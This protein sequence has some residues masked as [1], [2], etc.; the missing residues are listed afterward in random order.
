MDC[1]FL[2]KTGN[3]TENIGYF[4]DSEREKA[5]KG[6]ELSG[7]AL[8][9]LDQHTA[10]ALDSK[11]SPGSQGKRERISNIKTLHF[12][13]T[14][15]VQVKGK[16]KEI[17][18]KTTRTNA[19]IHSTCPECRREIAFTTCQFC[20]K[21]E[22]KIDFFLTQIKENIHILKQVTHHLV[23]DGFYA[24]K[25]FISGSNDLGLDVITKLRVDANLQYLA[26]ISHQ[27]RRRGAPKK[28]DG[29]F[30]VKDLSRFEKTN[31]QG[32]VLYS[33]EMY[34]P[35]FQRNLKIVVI[36]HTI[37]CSTD[38]NL[39]AQEIF[40]IYS[41]R[42]QIEYLFR[43]GKSHMGLGDAQVR[44]SCSLNFQNNACLT[45]L[46]LL[47]LEHRKHQMKQEVI[48]IFSYKHQRYN[49]N[50]I[51][52]VLSKLGKNPK[53]YKNHEWYIA[54]KNLGSISA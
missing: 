47:K 48:S 40:E 16:L 51:D 31:H 26:E 49:Q 18:V 30:D 6:L 35:Q 2:K 10:Y 32:L 7:L 12:E 43:D 15:S 27:E 8:I 50:L 42:F 23:V 34:S 52:L 44:K 21:Q 11:L 45:A 20:E 41:A 1:S 37:L 29:K 53:F 38:L 28:Y 14:R 22:T 36:D 24:K 33:K 46:N 54:L 19:Y 3:H 25:K 13:R 4:Y 5:E 9:D 39:S 17:H